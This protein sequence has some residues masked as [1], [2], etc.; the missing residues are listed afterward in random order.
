VQDEDQ[1]EARKA[2]R[3][4]S[5]GQ[6]G[7]SLIRQGVDVGRF[8]GMAPDSDGQWGESRALNAW[9]VVLDPGPARQASP[10]PRNSWS[11]RILRWSPKT[12]TPRSCWEGCRGPLGP[13]AGEFV[14]H[15]GPQFGQDLLDVLVCEDFPD[16]RHSL[17][18]ADRRG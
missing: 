9:A 4:G 7:A 18:R 3:L 14:H 10:C 2:P 12:Q 17:Y 13:G 6:P 5:W 11:P 16:Q 15:L 8:G 1:D